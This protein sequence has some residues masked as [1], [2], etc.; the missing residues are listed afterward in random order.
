MKVVPTPSHES[1]V[2]LSCIVGS[3]A[4]PQSPAKRDTA[5]HIPTQQHGTR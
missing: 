5:A 4:I 2:V 3:P 1:L